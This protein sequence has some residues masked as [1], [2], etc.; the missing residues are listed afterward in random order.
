MSSLRKYLSFAVS[1]AAVWFAYHLAAGLDTGEEAGGRLTGPL[2]LACFASVPFLAA[3]IACHSRFRMLGLV[4]W[5]GG[6]ALA[7]PLATWRLAPGWWSMIS[8]WPEKGERAPF[9]LDW[10]S[11]A[12]LV[13]LLVSF[14]MQSRLSRT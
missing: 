6:A 13:C 1:A 11:I 7:A 5:I 14:G 9:Y 4:L 3:S 2:I 8:P 10:L 12:L